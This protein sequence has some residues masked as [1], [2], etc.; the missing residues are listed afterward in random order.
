MLFWLLCVV[1]CCIVMVMYLCGSVLVWWYFVVVVLCGV[2]LVWWC[3]GVF[4][5]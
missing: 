1:M 2:V 4:V 5:W 3:G